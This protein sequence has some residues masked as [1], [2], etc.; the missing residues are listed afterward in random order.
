M[1]KLEKFLTFLFDRVLTLVF[2]GWFFV[3]LLL[4]GLAAVLVYITDSP[5]IQ[6]NP[7]LVWHILRRVDSGFQLGLSSYFVRGWLLGLTMLL[8]L[9]GVHRPK[10]ALSLLGACLAF[11]ALAFLSAS[12]SSHPFDAFVTSLDSLL[13]L[14]VAWSACVLS[15]SG[16]WVPRIILASGLLVT[17]VSL[18]LYPSA[19]S[20]ESRLAGTFHQPNMTATYLTSLLPWLINQEIRLSQRWT[21]VTLLVLLAVVIVTLTLTATRAAWLIAMVSLCARWWVGSFVK[22]GPLNR[23]KLAATVGLSLGFTAT[24]VLALKIPLILGIALAVLILGAWRSELQGQNF[25]LLA[26]LALCLTIGFSAQQ[27]PS[28]S[29][30]ART[31]DLSGGQDGSLSARVEFLRTSLNMG[32]DHPWLGVGPRGFHRYYPSY[33]ADERWFSKFAH[34]AP[35]SV[36]AEVGVFGFLLLGWL[37]FLWLA[38]VYRGLCR[39][40]Q[41]TRLQIADGFTACLILSLCSCLDVQWQFPMLPV[42]WAAWIGYTLARCWPQSHQ[43]PSPAA[44]TP[45]SAWTLRPSVVLSYFMVSCLGILCALN[46]LW[47]AAQHNAD[48]A[49]LALQRA[50]IKEA[51]YFD[52]LSIELNPFQGSYHH[53]L[54]LSLLAGLASKLEGVTAQQITEAAQRAISLDSH[55]AVHYDLLAKSYSHQKKDA[56]ATLAITKALQCD[57]VNYPSFYTQLAGLHLNKKDRSRA[58]LIL[59]SCAQRFPPESFDT[60]FNF[61]SSEMNRQLTDVYL[62]LADLADPKAQPQRALGY[63]DKLLA[64][65]PRQVDARL[66]RL[67]CLVNLNRLK[68]ARQDGLDYFRTQPSE[69]LVEIM[70]AIYHF[71]GLPFREEEF[72]IP[73]TQAK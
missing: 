40:D 42:T 36:W 72:P 3:L 21:K 55:R 16:N 28:Q 17:V 61:R 47:T 63:Y 19:N 30:L 50:K 25:F 43:E 29:L 68:E 8:F 53:H 51:I 59:E 62:L 71:E 18:A 57:P 52:R 14:F 64:I 34:S 15:L 11:H 5:S 10:Q 69:A 2:Q 22:M 46:L 4:P 66:G 37:G 39:A 56:E 45:V 9:L 60:M 26:F 67:V 44:P 38:H 7:S 12:L 58:E 73:S 13:L 54:G 6:Q 33:Q 1:N 23:P 41:E 20:G 24:L 48:I 65:E 31:A 35:A 32:L 27:S 49:D 70:K